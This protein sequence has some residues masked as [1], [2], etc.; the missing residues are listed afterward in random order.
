MHGAEQSDTAYFAPVPF[1]NETIDYEDRLLLCPAELAVPLKQLAAAGQPVGKFHT[2][3]TYELDRA[4]RSVD[5][6]LEQRMSFKLSLR[7][8]GLL[9]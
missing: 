4:L 5:S 3:T 7:Q 9:V 1:R 2:V 8:C 6:S